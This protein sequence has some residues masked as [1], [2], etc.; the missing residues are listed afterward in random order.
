[1]PRIRETKTGIDYFSHDT[2]LFHD[3]K[4][5]ILFAKHGL[6]G[7]A[8]YLRLLEKVYRDKGYYLHLTEVVD[9]LFC[10]VNKLTLNVYILIL[11]DCI[12]YELFDKKMYEKYNILTSCRIQNNYISATQRRKDVYFYKEYLLVD[13]KDKYN[14]KTLNV[15]ILA[16]NVDNGT[17]S[18][19][20]ESK[21]KNK[22]IFV[23]DSKEFQLSLFLQDLILKNNPNAKTHD[24]QGWSKHIDYMIRIDNREVEQIKKVIEFSQQ[25]P[26]WKSN[27]L[28]T[29]KLREKFDTLWLQK[30]G[31][32]NKKKLLGE[33]KERDICEEDIEDMYFDPFKEAR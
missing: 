5:E 6:I 20:K 29:K 7:Y 32:K 21:V 14:S 15:N 1:M 25:D 33:F 4:V 28:S 8:V 26:F 10:S 23:E 2:D 30:D 13:L 19:V 27:I 12:K 22:N 11:N 24:L 3:D 31:I 16:L 17:Q 9:I 18:K